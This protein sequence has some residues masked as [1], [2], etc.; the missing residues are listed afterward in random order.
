MPLRRW[1]LFS[2]PPF[3]LL[4]L[5]FEEMVARCGC[6][7]LDGP[8]PGSLELAGGTGSRGVAI[9]EKTG[10]YA[11]ENEKKKENKGNTKGV[12][13]GKVSPD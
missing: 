6:V 13:D 4:T 9:V 3:H 12:C 2:L 11:G 8:S 10:T 7:T 5:E 1:P